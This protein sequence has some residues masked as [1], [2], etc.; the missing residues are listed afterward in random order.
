MEG[1]RDVRFNLYFNLKFHL[2]S[3]SYIPKGILFSSGLRVLGAQLWLAG[4]L[5]G[6]GVKYLT[7]GYYG[8]FGQNLWAF[9][10]ALTY[11]ST[12]IIPL[13]SSQPREH[14]DL[15]YLQKTPGL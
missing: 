5:E 10:A 4:S 12:R 11:I 1:G 14:F 6:S 2:D 3:I 7:Q 9:R 13:S 8:E 15:K